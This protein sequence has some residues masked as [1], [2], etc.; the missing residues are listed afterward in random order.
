MHS[1]RRIGHVR[2]TAQTEIDR[3]RMMQPVFHCFFE[4]TMSQEPF[5]HLA[6][7]TVRFWVLVDGQLV[8]ASIPKE[9]LHY[10][11]H[12]QNTDDDPL[13]TYT[14][15]AAEID[16]AVRRRVATGS[17]EPVMLRDADVR[18]RPQT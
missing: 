10:R 18:A 9:T 3:W 15:N 11:Y 1:G 13:A 14:A 2:A 5:F 17:T 4:A 12:A 8:G 7:G 16:A 6:S